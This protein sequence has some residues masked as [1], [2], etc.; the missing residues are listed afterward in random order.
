MGS[1]SRITQV[2]LF[3]FCLAAP[4][5]CFNPDIQD[6]GFSCA[7][8]ERCPEGFSCV[9]EGGKKIC[10]KEGVPIT[11]GKVVDASVT[12]GPKDTGGK[13]PTDGPRL[14]QATGED[15]KPDM[16]VP[17]P[18]CP[19]ADNKVAQGVSTGSD[20]FD[21]DLDKNGRPHFVY[22]EAK[23]ALKHIALGPATI[24]Y[25]VSQSVTVA[26]ALMTTHNRFNVVYANKAAGDVLRHQ[27]QD[28]ANP[29]YWTA[30]GKIWE[31]KVE[32]VDIDTAGNHIYGAAKGIEATET[33]IY[34]F[35]ISAPN[36][37]VYKY[38]SC[39]P[40]ATKDTY[41]PIRAAQGSKHY[42]HTSYL[43][44]TSGSGEFH[45]YT[46][47][48]ACNYPG[49]A[50]GPAVSVPRP[51]AI[52]VD[53]NDKHHFAFVSA[54]GTSGTLV[55]V[56]WVPPGGFP[57][58]GKDIGKDV[59]P[60]SVDMA[61]LDMLKPHISYF[62]GGTSPALRWA[63]E[64]T[65]NGWKSVL[66]RQGKGTETRMRIFKDATTKAVTVH[67]AYRV[68]TALLHTCKSYTP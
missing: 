60:V 55:Y 29:G 21:F 66:V 20:T 12:D 27:A 23:G 19:S 2:L 48:S 40:N 7:K 15:L 6:G 65:K 39:K 25:T 57:S 24:P 31:G 16:P 49:E 32:S 59:V 47:R 56:P 53:T 18:L 42:A 43:K 30:E 33:I 37:G 52:A 1:L 36:S 41:G 46:R 64:D 14:D 62:V 9:P 67:F 22:V 5:S 61:L 63:Y 34:P 11:D 68:G 50:K 51:M 28:M 38:S 58:N 44:T 4:L 8:N 26:A 54:A 13:P 17:P 35:T 45:V 10:R 3:C